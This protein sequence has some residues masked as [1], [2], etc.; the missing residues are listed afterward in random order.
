MVADTPRAAPVATK[1]AESLGDPVI[2]VV[3]V[4]FCTMVDGGA[5]AILTGV[6]A[7]T[8]VLL[9]FAVM[10]DVFARVGA[11]LREVGARL[12]SGNA[13]SRI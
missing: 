12:S 2:A 11:G 7:D 1:G 5:C 6:G 10:E 13:S 9:A 3:D 4:L 8:S